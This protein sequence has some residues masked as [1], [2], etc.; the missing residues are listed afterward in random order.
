MALPKIDNPTYTLELPST[1]EV[2]KYRPFLVKEQ[3]VL[4]LAQ[5]SKVDRDRNNA[6]LEIIESC[7]FG[8]VG[9]KNPLFDIEY[10]FLKLRSKSAGESVD[11]M[12]TCPDDGKTKEK[13]TINIDEID[14]NMTE[15]HTNKLNITDTIT[16]NMRYPLIA[17]VDISNASIQN[18]LDGSFKVVKRCIETISDG[19][20]VHTKADYTEKELDDF[21]NSFNTDQLKTVMSF[22]ETMP[23]LRHPVKVKNSK[24]GVESDVILEGLE[25]FL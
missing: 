24:T 21:L 23:K 5:Q 17:D 7:T 22:F 14:V 18:D 25:S 2:V 11:V 8:K 1:G 16:M 3:K 9:A 6:I 10:V 13:V 4:M 12:I 19:D 20:T 15:T